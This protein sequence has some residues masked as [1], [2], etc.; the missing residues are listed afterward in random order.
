MVSLAKGTVTSIKNDQKNSIQRFLL[1]SFVP[2]MLCVMGH[3]TSLST[4][5]AVHTSMKWANVNMISWRRHL[6]STGC[7]LIAMSTLTG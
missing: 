5:L 1:S 4:H 6:H 2:V 7:Q 3:A